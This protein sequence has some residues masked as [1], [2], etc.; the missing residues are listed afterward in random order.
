MLRLLVAIHLAVLQQCV[1]INTVV[2]YG[3]AIVVKVF[4][5]LKNLIPVL[6]N[7]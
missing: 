4:P 6:L 5:D 2:A 1:G 7:L 3:P